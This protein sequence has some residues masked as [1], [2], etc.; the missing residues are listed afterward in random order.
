M[1]GL[2]AF[3]FRKA[4]KVLIETEISSKCNNKGKWPGFYRCVFLSTCF[5]NLMLM[6]PV[7]KICGASKKK[8]K[9]SAPLQRSQDTVGV[10]WGCTAKV[11]LF[12]VIIC[13][14]INN[15]H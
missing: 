5:V 15:N 12:W 13:F 2:I 6:S 7:N 1:E 11:C 4:L 10:I 3:T 14:L 9:I 8:G